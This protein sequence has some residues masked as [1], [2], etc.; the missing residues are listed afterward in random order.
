VH[1]HAAQAVR[2]GE[3]LCVVEAMKMELRI[4]APSDGVVTRVLVAA[5]DRVERGQRLVEFEPA[6]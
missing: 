5:G 2:R 4:E 3:L 6:A 1:A